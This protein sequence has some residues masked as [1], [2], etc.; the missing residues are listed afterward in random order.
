M[1]KLWYSESGVPQINQSV[2]KLLTTAA[3]S[4]GI[5]FANASQLQANELNDA[6]T[7][8]NSSGECFYAHRMYQLE[9]LTQGC[10]ETRRVEG[11]MTYTVCRINGRPV[12][13]SESL[14]ELGDGV[15]YWFENG[16]VVAIQRF[17]DGSTIFFNRG[18]LAE[19]YFDGGS[20]VQSEF[21]ATERQELETLARNGYRDIFRKLN[22]R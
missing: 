21:S 15:G 4:I 22:V 11:N 3:F 20:Q 17:H 18:K 1:F 8:D 7:C 14:T 12:R 13:A 9:Q 16:K 19:V 2:F 10:R 6:P 5:L